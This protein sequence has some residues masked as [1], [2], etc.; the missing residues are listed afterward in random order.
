MKK[1]I[2][3]E[4]GFFLFEYTA[5]NTLSYFPNTLETGKMFLLLESEG[6]TCLNRTTPLL[7]L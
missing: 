2:S 4:I 6:K 3:V 7:D 5:M 1:P